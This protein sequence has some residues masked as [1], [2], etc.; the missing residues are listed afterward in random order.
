MFSPI[1]PAATPAPL[2]AAVAA[3]PGFSAV[4]LP[5]DYKYGESAIELEAVSSR[6]TTAHGKEAHNTVSQVD[7]HG[8]GP[9]N[10]EKG[11]KG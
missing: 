10:D 2:N 1:S 3:A 8:W 11:S 7:G 6:P 4:E 9:L 5:A